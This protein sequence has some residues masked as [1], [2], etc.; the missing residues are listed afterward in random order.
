MQF[1]WDAPDRKTSFQIETEAEAALESAL[2][3]HAVEKHFRQTR[4]E[5]ARTNAPPTGSY[6]E[7]DIGLKAHI[8]RDMP[9]FLL[10]PSGSGPSLDE[11]RPSAR[12]RIRPTSSRKPVQRLGQ[13]PMGRELFDVPLSR[14]FTCVV[15]A[16]WVSICAATPEIIW[17][18]FIALS[19]HFS[20]VQ[21]YSVLFIAML[22]AFFVDPVVERIKSGSWELEHQGARDLLYAA[23]ISLVFGIAAV[24]VHEAMNA[25]LG[26]SHTV[27]AAEHDKQTT[28]IR[29]IEQ[30]REWASIPFVV[31]AA[32]FIAPMRRWI[33][34][35]AAV[36]ACAWIVAIG[37]YYGWDWHVIVTTAVPCCVISVL[38]CW[39]VSRQW[40]HTTF[41]VLAGLT[42]SVAGL[43]FVL[44]WLVPGCARLLGMPDF[45]LYTSAGFF[46]DVRF[47]LGWAL[48]LA[49]A[50]NPV[51]SG[52]N[53]AIPPEAGDGVDAD[54]HAHVL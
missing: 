15:F 46:E 18:G 35:L 42:A 6:I 20:R 10:R 39:L 17:E 36:L 4:D 23:I 24:C 48:G 51:P 52:A 32:W 13:G 34:S 54:Q 14:V 5:A 47:F 19:G 41:P 8:Q 53:A 50:P 38:G 43:W 16:F 33:A 26:G 27:G 12:L 31:T 28:L 45:H 3:C 7:Q 49:V 37:A 40:D 11:Q 1:V 44:A 2:M 25:Y 22:L 30:V 9:V 21:V 29:A